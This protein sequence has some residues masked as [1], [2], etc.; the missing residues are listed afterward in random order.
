MSG[1]IKI[2]VLRVRFRIEKTWDVEN[3]PLHPGWG[4]PAGKPLNFECQDRTKYIRNSVPY[5]TRLTFFF[6]NVVRLWQPVGNRQNLNEILIDKIVEQY[7]P[8]KWIHRLD[9]TVVVRIELRLSQQVVL[10][11]SIHLRVTLLRF[12]QVTADS[13]FHLVKCYITSPPI[14]L[15]IFVKMYDFF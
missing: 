10:L 13:R 14:L 2:I 1:R 12:R 11:F 4:K 8:Q 3:R 5:N 15:V 9:L 7:S 6:R